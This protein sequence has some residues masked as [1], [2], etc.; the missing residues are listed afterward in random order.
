MRWP[1]GRVLRWPSTRGGGASRT[2]ADQDRAGPP[3]P[4]PAAH[5]EGDCDGSL[6]G[7]GG[8]VVRVGRVGTVVTH[9]DGGVM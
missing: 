4:T 5:S 8:R 2:A 1:E 9:Q 7:S 3:P 6:P